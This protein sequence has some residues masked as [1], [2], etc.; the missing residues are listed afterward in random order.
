MH[1]GSSVWKRKNDKFLKSWL[2]LS[3]QMI[4]LNKEKKNTS[5]GKFTSSLSNWL[6]YSNVTFLFSDAL[7]HQ[8]YEVESRNNIATLWEIVINVHRDSKQF[9]LRIRMIP[10]TV[11]MILSLYK[12][13][14]NL[15]HSMSVFYIEDYVFIW[16]MY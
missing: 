6:T 7:K 11:L 8:V 14:F 1:S 2:S 16:P 4:M 15:E 12:A 10:L 9:L 3:Q 5:F 13:K